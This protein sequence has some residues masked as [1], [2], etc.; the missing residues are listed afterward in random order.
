MIDN[1]KPLLD[2]FSVIGGFSG[3]LISVGII[4]IW[5]KKPVNV[6]NKLNKGAELSQENKV[7]LDTLEPVISDMSVNLKSIVERQDQSE[8]SRIR[9]HIVDFVKDL[10]RGEPK[11]EVEFEIMLDECST[12]E[13]LKGNGII[14]NK[15]IPYIRQSNSQENM[16]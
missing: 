15:Y 1:I 3:A 7:R 10:E 4:Y 16:V 8:I 13:T 11:S 2:F 6:F 12:Y 14:K 9:V 5:I